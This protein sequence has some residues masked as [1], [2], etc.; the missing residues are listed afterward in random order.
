MHVESRFSGQEWSLLVAGS[1]RARRD[2]LTQKTQVRAFD[3]HVQRFSAG[4][5]RFAPELGGEVESF[6]ATAAQQIDDFG[7][8]FPRLELLAHN[9][10]SEPQLHLSLRPL[11][12]LTDTVTL[13]TVAAP[14]RSH[15]D[16]KGPNIRLYAQMNTQY[17]A[18]CLMVENG[19][20]TEGTTTSLLLWRRDTP[21]EQQQLIVMPELNRVRSVTENI[22]RSWA[23]EQLGVTVTTAIVHPEE[24]TNYE[25]WCV[26]ALH[27][28]RPV[29]SI[30]EVECQP[31]N[32]QLLML[33]RQ[34]ID[35]TWQNVSI[36]ADRTQT[37]ST[38]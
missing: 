6:I 16:I 4:V 7:D 26:N 30:N 38:N 28:I 17:Q 31:A 11:P 10:T 18:E 34:A 2:P 1:F 22:I 5:S 13:V 15:S 33:A 9:V 19:V 3:Q 20:V 24:L 8:G 27:G 14:V 12:Q 36:E 21:H 25:I 29:T 37:H 35:T 23:S 32:A